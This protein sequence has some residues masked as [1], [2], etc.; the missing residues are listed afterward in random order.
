MLPEEFCS[1]VENQLGW[2][3]GVGR[4]R[5]NKMA[6]QLRRM[7]EKGY[8][9]RYAWADLA[10]AVRYMVLENIWDRSP[11]TV[12]AYIKSAKQAAAEREQPMEE[13]RRQLHLA[14]QL[15]TDPEEAERL[16]RVSPERA[17]AALEQWKEANRGH[18]QALESR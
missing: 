1:Y 14:S 10:L 3:P 18:R 15:E 13:V 4:E 2:N 12:D 8:G 17:R 5:K 16:L 7:E 9:T 11:S 6:Y